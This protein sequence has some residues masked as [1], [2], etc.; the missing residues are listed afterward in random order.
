[1]TVVFL[2]YCWTL[3]ALHS[4]EYEKKMQLN[5]LDLQMEKET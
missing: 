1:M 4:V 5:D 3:F 2:S